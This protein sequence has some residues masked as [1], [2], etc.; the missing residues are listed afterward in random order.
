MPN[1]I[2]MSEDSVVNAQ[3]E[4]KMLQMQFRLAKI[5]EK[6]DNIKALQEDVQ[7]IIHLIRPPKSCQLSER[8]V[9]S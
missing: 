5:D 9:Q 7:S 6:G 3:L 4:S 8:R 2:G 1:D